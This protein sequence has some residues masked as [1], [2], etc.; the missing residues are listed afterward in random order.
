MK[1]LLTIVLAGGML[2]FYACGSSKAEQE[3]KEK[4]KQDSI[5]MA[6]SVAAAE[7]ASAAA[8]K[9]KAMQDSVAAVAAAS[10][11]KAMEDSVAAAQAKGGKG[12]AKSTEQ[13]KA[14]AKK[15]VSGRG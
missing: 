2:A 9:E 11:Q 1:K 7:A 3:A 13:K 4:A 15:V 10:K 12:K 6:D 8:A 5:H 14:E